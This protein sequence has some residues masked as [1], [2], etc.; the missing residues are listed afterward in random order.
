[1]G[2]KFKMTVDKIELEKGLHRLGIRELEERL[3][4]SP[5]VFGGQETDEFHPDQG[6]F[7][8]GTYKEDEYP[9]LMNDN[10]VPIWV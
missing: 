8:C 2:E 3:E 4:V 1:M 6:L 7:N 10:P 9:D 5:L